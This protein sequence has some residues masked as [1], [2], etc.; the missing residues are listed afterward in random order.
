VAHFPRYARLDLDLRRAQVL[1]RMTDA[2]LT[3]YGVFE[4]LVAIALGP[5]LRR[6]GL[7]PVH[8]FAAAWRDQA[9]LLVGARGSGKTTTGISLLRAGWRLLSND[10]PLL[11]PDGAGVAV[12]SYPGLLSAYPDTL[13][14]FPELRALAPADHPAGRKISFAA[15][16]VYPGAWQSRATA[17]VLC[18]PRVSSGGAHRLLSLSAPEAL[19]L[20]LP[21]A[22]DRWDEATVAPHFT[23]LSALTRAAPAYRLEL[24]PEVE[25]LPELLASLV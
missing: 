18:F 25:A 5:Y 15:E 13:A 16:S 20:L 14:R 4:D 3:T 21:N 11:A 7:F 9:A 6:R 12:L 17:T 23:T 24:G 8:A 10:A 19:R 1:G 2:A 22:I